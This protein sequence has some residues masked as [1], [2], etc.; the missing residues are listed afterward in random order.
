MK[1][2]PALVCAFFVF[3][4]AAAGAEIYNA[5]GEMAGEATATSV[6]LQ[7]RLTAISGPV[8]DADGDVPGAA[9]V[10]RF[11]WSDSADFAKA[12][13]SA[14][15]SAKAES[16]FIVRTRAE[17]LKP[18]TVYHYRLQ[19]GE[20]E[21]SAKTGP[22]RSFKT[23]PAPDSVA[24]L[25]FCMGSCMNYHSFMSGKAN[26][27]GPVTATDED[28]RLGYPSFAAMATL[29]P[30]FFIGT[31]DIVYY[32]HP[33]DTAARTLPELR[34]KWHEQ[35]RFP[36]LI[37]F[38]GRTP[39]Y[40]S[41]DDHDFRYND[42]DLGGGKDP[43]PTTGI[44]LFRE[45]MPIH[46]AGDGTTPTYRTH[47]VHRH[48]QLWF[49]EG[50]DYR[51]PNKMPDGPE[52]SIWG[53]EQRDWLKRTLKESDATWKIIITPTPMVGPD[54]NS[55]TDNHANLSGFKHE[56]D[57]FF[58]YLKDEGLDNVFTFCGDR[59]WQYHSIHPLGVEEFSVGAL[60][61]ENAIRGEKP[62]GPKTTDPEGKIKQP[63]LYPAPTG[64]FLRVEVGEGATKAYLRI[65]LRDDLGKVAYRVENLAEG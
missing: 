29:K 54:R 63:F 5:Q 39:A 58:H 26:G 53:A 36:R 30:D 13:Q 18:G 19:F 35:F 20:T 22:V 55:K 50:R 51:S 1:T 10:A 9:G 65:E 48:L 57:A 49:T 38:F 37:E 28:K 25:T 11:E 2:L 41:K 4:S 21:A 8:L 31:G 27:G 24:P 60:N 14:W 40:W 32:D 59:H 12:G 34:R 45:Q 46:G 3:A 47:R 52:K 64:G 17:G 44:G 56:A 16:D 42:A 43:A 61:D 6:L 23:L 33:A 15:L 7:G 62:G